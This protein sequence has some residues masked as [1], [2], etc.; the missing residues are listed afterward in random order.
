[1]DFIV[2][3][4]ALKTIAGLPVWPQQVAGGKYVR[5]LEKFL[6]DLR[7]EDSHGNR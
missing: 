3:K 1:M 2:G 4:G 7:R 5:L 6:R